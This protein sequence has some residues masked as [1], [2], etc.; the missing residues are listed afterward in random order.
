MTR[1]VSRTYPR[2]SR[3]IRCTSCGELIAQGAHY[4]R[5]TGT[6][7]YWDGLATA[8]ECAECCERYGRPIP[9]DFREHRRC[10]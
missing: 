4:H 6:G 5:W 1:T 9:V 2:A 10:R 7:D 8:K 3:A